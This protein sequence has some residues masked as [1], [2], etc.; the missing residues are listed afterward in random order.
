MKDEA[1]EMRR[2][3][4]EELSGLGDMIR[5]TLVH[6]TR[7]C[8]RKGCH[9]MTGGAKHDVCYMTISTRHARNR[10]VH[11]ARSIEKKVAEGIQ[12]YK[13]AWEILE[14]LGRLNLGALKA[15]A[16]AEKEAMKRKAR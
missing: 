14:E 11:I 8:G 6:T 3:L 10:T 1:K 15:T 4:L 5:G 16:R 13:R 7:K 12:A 2:K 9:C